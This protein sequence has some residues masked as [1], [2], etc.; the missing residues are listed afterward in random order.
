MRMSNSVRKAAESYFNACGACLAANVL[1]L[2]PR[3]T[4]PTQ[5]LYTYVCY[6]PS[7]GEAS[8]SGE[9]EELLAGTTHL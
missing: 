4:I 3:A 2:Y 7:R 6:I 9:S 5:L 8:K 1:T